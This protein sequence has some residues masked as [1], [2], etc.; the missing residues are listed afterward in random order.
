[1][2][3]GYRKTVEKAL[4]YDLELAPKTVLILDRIGIIPEYRNNKIGQY[5]IRNI[6]ERYSMGAFMVAVKPV[7]FPFD[8]SHIINDKFGKR[9][10]WETGDESADNSS[11]IRFY[12]KQGFKKSPGMRF[13]VLCTEQRLPELD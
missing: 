13:M 8:K 7:M 3:S 4:D 10:N 6:I 1:V 9:I 5:I 11:L 2:E 12:K